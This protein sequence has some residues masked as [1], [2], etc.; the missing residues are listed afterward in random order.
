MNNEK[1]LSPV[2]SFIVFGAVIGLVIYGALHYKPIPLK[3]AGKIESNIPQTLDLTVDKDNHVRG[4]RNAEIYLV[5][6]SDTE[7][8]FCKTLHPTL[9]QIVADYNG[10]I[11]VEYR[12]FPLTIHPKARGEA[13]ATEC[14]AMLAGEDAFWKYID[15]IFEVTASNN[16]LSE[17]LL[18]T[19]AVEVG[20]N[21][22]E[23]NQCM[24]N[25]NGYQKA[26]VNENM[27]NG[28]RDGVN[29]TPFILI[30][31]NKQFVK[32]FSG[33]I[34]YDKLKVMIDGII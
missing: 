13:E 15:R 34:P 32:S 31:K 6:Y 10:K 3:K 18:P 19:L 27:Q 24:N 22:D 11:A 20:V 33:A 7:C 5:E 2:V 8:P 1:K 30:Y 14:V 4:D 21:V 16:S 17:S 25:P 28:E 26:M 23:F 12:H 29:G 9:K